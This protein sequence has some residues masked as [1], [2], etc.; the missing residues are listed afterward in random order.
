MKT[1]IIFCSVALSLLT[2]GTQNVSA[3]AKKTAPKKTA[4][5]TGG[6]KWTKEGLGYK[7]IRKTPATGVS[8]KLGDFVEMNI[9]V[10]VGD[11]SL[12]DSKAVNHGDPISFPIQK[13]AFGSDPVN[14]FMMMKAGDSAVFYVLVDS[15]KKSG[16]QLPPWMK[17]EDKL[18]YNVKLFSIKSEAEGK[19][20]AAKKKAAM[21]AEAAKQAEAQKSIDDKILT[22]YFAANHIKASKTSSGLYYTIATQ[23]TGENAK[24]GQTVTVNYTGKTLDGKAFDSNVDSNFHHVQPFSFPVGQHRVIAGWDEGIP[25]IKKGGKGTLYIPSPLAYGAHS[26]TAAIPANGILMFDVEVTDIAEATKPVSDEHN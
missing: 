4:A 22:D 5:T 18:V 9:K 14:G 13:P 1:S 2:I 19:A 26:P 11:S 7:I 16:A 10:H 25:L 3:Q 6:V 12:F 17:S 15:L 20:E 23:G 8:P 24:N 21:D